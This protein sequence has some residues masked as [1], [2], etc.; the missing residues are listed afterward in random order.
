MDVDGIKNVVGQD[1]VSLIKLF[2]DKRYLLDFP[3][4]FK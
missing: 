3:P 2:D 1:R 4:K